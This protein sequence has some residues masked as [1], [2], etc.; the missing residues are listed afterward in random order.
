E[1]A[2]DDQGPEQG[3]EQDP[4]AGPAVAEMRQGLHGRSTPRRAMS[5]VLVR[6]FREWPRR[7]PRGVVRPSAVAVPPGE[8]AAPPRL[9]PGRER[10]GSSRRGSG[11]EEGCAVSF[12]RPQPCQR[13]TST[14]ALTRARSRFGYGS[15]V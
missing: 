3:E 7:A 9:L 1:A 13:S 15:P 2:A 8:Y 11:Q 5:V 14:Q 6:R 12:I 4:R 10:P